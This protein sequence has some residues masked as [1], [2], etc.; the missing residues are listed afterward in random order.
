MIILIG[1]FE[2]KGGFGTIIHDAI[3]NKKIM[4]ADN[5]KWNSAAASIPIIF[6]GNIFNNLHQ[7]TASQDVVQRYQAS[8]SMEETKSHCGQTVY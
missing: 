5:W 2:I 8:D 6:L 3:A 4:S 7:Y 1:A